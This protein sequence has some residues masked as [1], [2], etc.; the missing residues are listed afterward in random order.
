[1]PIVIDENLDPSLYPLAWLVGAWEGT[2]AVQLKGENGEEVGHAIEQRL[3]VTPNSAKGLTW[4]MR[5]WVLNSPA[6]EPPTSAFY[7][8]GEE[9]SDASQQ[10]T[11]TTLVRELLLEEKGTWR[12]TGV[13]PGQDEEAAKNA[14]PGS[15]E[16][17]L[18]HGVSLTM[19]RSSA[20][21]EAP[22]E[23]WAGEVRGPRIQ[24][25]TQ[26]LAASSG[27]AGSDD[28]HGARM[29]GLVGGRLMW[30][31]EVGSSLSNLRPYLSVELNRAADEDVKEA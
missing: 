15:P 22:A 4:V 9:K 31:Q 21:G 1:M 27:A 24:L 14:K 12:T 19:E 6:P 5:T 25:A 13:L 2:G 26:D 7:E 17:Y 10:S 30:L 3:T 20:F 28:S 11:D 18:S 23:H 8:K 16:S 29:F